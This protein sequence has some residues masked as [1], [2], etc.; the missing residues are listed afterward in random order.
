MA[1]PFAMIPLSFA[2]NSLEPVIDERT[3]DIHY[4]KHYKGYVDRFN[5]V[6]RG[7]SEQS[8]VVDDITRVVH[9]AL[10]YQNMSLAELLT[11]LDTLPDSIREG[12]RNF[13]GGVYNH[14]LFWKTLTPERQ[15]PSPEFLAKINDAYGSFDEFKSQLSTVAKTLFGSGWAWLCVNDAGTLA[16]MGTQNQDSPLSQGLYPLFCIDVWEHAYYLKY[17]NRRAEFVDALWAHINWSGIE[18]RY[19]EYVL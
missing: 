14:E 18:K 6:L 16:I 7:V 19:D 4:H 15:D 9:D 3:M 1:Y 11:N 8:R 13:G 5:E 12:V 2:L 10:D 17:Q